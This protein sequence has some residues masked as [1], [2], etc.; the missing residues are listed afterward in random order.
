MKKFLVDMIV[1]FGG[2]FCFIYL[3]NP[4]AGWIEFIPDALPFFGNLDEVTATAM[5]LGC[6]SYFGYEGGRIVE[7]LR[8]LSGRKDKKLLTDNSKISK[9]EETES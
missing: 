4:F 2:C 3:L 7:A 9:S 6:L 5:F 8:I 1:F